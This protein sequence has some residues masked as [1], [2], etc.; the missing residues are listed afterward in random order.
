MIV[1]LASSKAAFDLRYFDSVHAHGMSQRLQ[2]RFNT[3]AIT[4]RIT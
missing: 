1:L 2:F 3:R 4:M